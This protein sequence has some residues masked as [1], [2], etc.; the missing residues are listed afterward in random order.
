M[1]PEPPLLCVEK[2]PHESKRLFTEHLVR[3]CLD[4]RVGEP[5]AV[6]DRLLRLA[7][8][9]EKRTNREPAAE[10][11]SFGKQRHP[12]FKCPRD[13]QDVAKMCVKLAHE[14]LDALAGR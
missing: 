6:H 2:H 8:V 1:Q 9:G 10:T 4:L 12:L 7:T 11:W 14:P 3:H 13:K 5:E